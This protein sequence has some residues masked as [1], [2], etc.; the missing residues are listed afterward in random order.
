[1][2]FI[3]QTGEGCSPRDTKMPSEIHGLTFV[4]FRDKLDVRLNSDA[5]SPHI[6]FNGPIRWPEVF[7]D[8]ENNYVGG[9]GLQN[10]QLSSLW[11]QM[12]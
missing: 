1:M 12:E 11:Y 7:P 8:G 9:Y 4:P 10:I 3:E 6:H 5:N 2:S